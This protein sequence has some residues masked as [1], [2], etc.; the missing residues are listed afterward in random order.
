MVDSRF[1]QGWHM[2]FRTSVIDVESDESVEDADVKVVLETG[3]KFE[4]EL[5]DHGTDDNEALLYTIAWTIPDDFPTGTLDY[6]IS[7][8][9]Q[10]GRKIIRRKEMSK[11]ISTFYVACSFF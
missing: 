2:V 3:E 10:G 6:E 11:R 9:F 4:M 7:D 1:E 8:I 5:A